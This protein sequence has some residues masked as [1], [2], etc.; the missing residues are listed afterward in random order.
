MK[1]NK[2]IR[3]KF[4]TLQDKFRTL[5]R[6]ESDL[7]ELERKGNDIQK[8]KIK[9]IKAFQ[10]VVDEICIDLKDRAE[11]NEKIHSLLQS[12]KETTSTL[13]TLL[14]QQS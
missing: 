6:L 14:T 2:T 13:K 1:K 8:A 10:G 3:D 7:S 9:K 5:S 11:K 12:L 4:R